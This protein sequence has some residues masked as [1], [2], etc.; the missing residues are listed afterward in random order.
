MLFAVIAVLTEVEIV[1]G[2]T[3]QPNR[4]HN[5]MHV[6]IISQEISRDDAHK[7]IKESKNQIFIKTTHHADLNHTTALVIIETHKF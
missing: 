2:L 6:A 5:W 1:N 7:L 4:L 3:Q